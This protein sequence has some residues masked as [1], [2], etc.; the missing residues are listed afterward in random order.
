MT[1][2]EVASVELFGKYHYGDQIKT[3]VLGGA[4]NTHTGETENSSSSLT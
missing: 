3:A 2:V 1:Y 4:C